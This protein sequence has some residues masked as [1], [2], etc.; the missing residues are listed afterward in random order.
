MLGD[1]RGYQLL[2]FVFFASSNGFVVFRNAYFE[3]LGLTGGQMGLLGALLVVGGM[4]AQPIWGG[5]ADRFA[6]SKPVL[7]IAA[8]V[9]SVAVLAF[10]LAGRV[11]DPFL[12][13]VLATALLSTVRSPIVPITNAMILSRGVDYGQVRAF[14]SI[15]FGLGSLVIGWL[16][17]RFATEIVFYIYAVGM[18]VL[19][20]I[21]RSVPD[22]DADLTPDLRRE[23]VKLLRNRRFLLLLGVAV[24]LGGASSSGSAYFSVYVRAIGAPDSLTGTAWMV[25]TVGEAV[26]FLSMAKI[27]LANRTQLSL[28]AALF[29]GCYL[30]YAAVGTATAIMAVQLVLG[31]GLALYNLAV[32]E[33]AHRFSPDELT[34]TGQAVL[35]AFGIGTGR[36]L[37]QLGAGNVMDLVGVQSMYFV[38]SALAAAALL[39]SLGF[40][41]P[42]LRRV[43]NAAGV[44]RYSNN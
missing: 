40:H 16:L 23:A 8:G 33:F 28:G 3:E 9:S 42:A 24:L 39:L 35:S 7:L 10:P 36:A 27:G 41:G 12:L 5:V 21:V 22:A 6:A 37:G 34:S 17:S 25:K 30:V 2:Y 13:L 38:L 32:V 4:I 20:L 26:I 11:P 15:A 14:G 1:K 19:I 43:G 18:V 31:V 44:G 29:A